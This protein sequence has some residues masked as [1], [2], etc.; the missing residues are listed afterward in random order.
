MDDNMPSAPSNQRQQAIARR[1]RD[2]YQRSKKD[3]EAWLIRLEKGGLAL[4]DEAARCAGLSRAAFFREVM[5][6]HVAALQ[7]SQRGAVQRDANDCPAAQ[8]CEE[9]DRLFLQPEEP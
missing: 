3:R 1:N 5:L 8:A 6:P 7:A 2:F 9:F 4:I